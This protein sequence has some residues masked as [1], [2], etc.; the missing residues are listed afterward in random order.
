MKLYTNNI[1]L[2][3]LLILSTL[4][5]YMMVAMRIMVTHSLKNAYLIWNL[6][7]AAAPYFM[8]VWI[9]RKNFK[10]KSV[11]FTIIGSLW[12]LFLPNAPYLITDLVHLQYT[13]S[14]PLWYDYSKLFFA[15]FVGMAWGLFSILSLENYIDKQLNLKHKPLL[16]MMLFGI[17]SY[18]V[19]LGRFLRWNSWDIFTRPLE[20][21]ISLKGTLC[22]ET[23][24]FVI[25][26]SVIQFFVYVVLKVVIN[27]K[28]ETSFA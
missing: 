11:K 12:L 3:K 26:F 10:V 24:A 14:V 15:S 9:K 4:T 5:I 20:F 6:F 28:G 13:D 27:S 1:S 16:I 23:F 17:V 25:V 22:F 18:G 19:Y 8:V 21:L 2:T 7:L